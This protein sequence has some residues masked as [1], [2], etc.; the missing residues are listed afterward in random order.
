[1]LIFLIM[2]FCQVSVEWGIIPPPVFVQYFTT[3]IY[4]RLPPNMVVTIV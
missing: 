2:S 1:M 3:I 4:H